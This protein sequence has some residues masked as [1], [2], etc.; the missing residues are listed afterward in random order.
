MTM[1]PDLM[2]AR[3]NLGHELRMTL[4]DPAEN[5]ECRGALRLQQEPEETA[6]SYA[7]TV[8]IGRPVRRVFYK[9]MEPI[10][11]VDREETWD[12]CR[13]LWASSHQLTS[14]SL[15]GATVLVVSATHNERTSW[16]Q[17]SR[18]LR[19]KDGP[20]YRLQAVPRTPPW[21]SKPWVRE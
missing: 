16:T 9:R 11:H 7:C 19:R 10:L 8:L 14:S 15:A 13:R 6:N 4:G 18:L 12:G 1:R 5:E 3:A 17:L 2:T 21:S 20:F